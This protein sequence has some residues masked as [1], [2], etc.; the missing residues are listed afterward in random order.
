MQQVASLSYNV[1]DVQTKNS[2]KQ[3]N[4]VLYLFS[5]KS[6]EGSLCY[7][8]SKLGI[9]VDEY[10]IE[11]TP[12]HDLSGDLEWQEI[13]K[14]IRPGYYALVFCSHCAGPSVVPEGGM[15]DHNH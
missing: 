11:A 4:R 10:D 8:L 1:E 6:R 5:G 3:C 7:W 13:F 2:H 15:E 14:R 9:E 12:S